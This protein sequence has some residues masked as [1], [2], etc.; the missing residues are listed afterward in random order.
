MEPRQQEK[1]QPESVVGLLDVDMTILNMNYKPGGESYLLNEAL[2]DAYKE[3]GIKDLYLFTNMKLDTLVTEFTQDTMRGV[4]VKLPMKRAEIVNELE[5]RGF[6]VH[7][8]ITPADLGYKHGLGAA[9]REIYLPQYE[10]FKNNKWKNPLDANEDPEFKEMMKNMHAYAQAPDDMNQ[11]ETAVQYQELY[12][13]RK[14]NEL[15]DVGNVDF[16][17]KAP[18]YQYFCDTKP[19]IV[20]AVVFADDDRGCINSVRAV[21]EKKYPKMPSAQLFVDN[22]NIIEKSKMMLKSKEIDMV[23]TKKDTKKIFDQ[24]KY[25]EMKDHYKKNIMVQLQLNIPMEK[26]LEKGQR[27]FI[28]H[29]LQQLLLKAETE[30]SNEKSKRKYCEDFQKIN[31]KIR[32]IIENNTKS[33]EQKLNEVVIILGTALAEEIP[34]LFLSKKK[35]ITAFQNNLKSEKGHDYI[36]IL[37]LALRNLSEKHNLTIKLEHISEDALTAALNAPLPKDSFYKGLFPRQ[38]QEKPIPTFN[39][40]QEKK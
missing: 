37:A 5:K 17:I 33:T 15:E 38:V 23:K 40:S 7:E 19:K 22:G 3:L 32:D 16:N 29:D 14:T 2:L 26:S 21:A 1:A 27:H 24:A 9:Y 12:K 18:L 10:K 39:I 35:D 20:E 6:I 13:N 11:L 8:V 34:T 36:K 4:D 30:C 28:L 25:E 31:K